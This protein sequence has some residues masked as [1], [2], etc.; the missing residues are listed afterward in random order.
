MGG[1]NIQPIIGYK[2]KDD[3]VPDLMEALF[4]LK[5]D[6]KEGPQCRVLNAMR[7]TE[8]PGGDDMCAELKDEQRSQPNKGSR[9]AY[10]W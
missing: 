7:T 8:G 3:S 9:K 4:Q 1:H 10:S 6:I 2:V 5:E